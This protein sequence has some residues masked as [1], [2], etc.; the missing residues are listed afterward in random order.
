MCKGLQLNLEH[1]QQKEHGR[2]L[3]VRGH[4]QLGQNSV[5][6]GAQEADTWTPSWSSGQSFPEGFQDWEGGGENISAS[7]TSF[8]A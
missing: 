3:E 6:K 2:N 5:L 1:T 8:L 4:R 7:S